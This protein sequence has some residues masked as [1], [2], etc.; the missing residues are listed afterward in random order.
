MTRAECSESKVRGAPGLAISG[1]MGPRSSEG[2]RLSPEPGHT[3]PSRGRRRSAGAFELREGERDRREPVFGEAMLVAVPQARHIELQPVQHIRIAADGQQRRRSAMGWDLVAD[4]ANQ[5]DQYAVDVLL[6]VRRAG[7]AAGRVGPTA[8]TVYRS[9]GWHGLPQTCT[10]HTAR[11]R[12]IESF[13]PSSG[14][15]Q[16]VIPIAAMLW[17]TGR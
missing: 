10:S 16:Q 1:C 13:A 14:A 8:T 3:P 6:G 17:V 11:A 9:I 7:Q 15:D 2:H 12:Q 4:E 5:F